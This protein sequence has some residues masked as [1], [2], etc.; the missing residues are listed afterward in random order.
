MCRVLNISEFWIFVNLWNQVTS[1]NITSKTQENEAPQGNIFEFFLLGTL[2][3]TFSMKNLT[4]KFSVSKRAGKATPLPYL[5]AWSVAEYASV[6]LSMPKYPWKCL[7]KLFWLCQGF[8]YAWS[9]YM[10]DRLLK[11]PRVLNKPRFWIWHGCICK[12]YAGFRI[13]SDYGSIRLSNMS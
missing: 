8:D 13:L 6:S 4:Q 1:I 11:M 9:S 7:N 3:T 5:P 2:K 10:F 12:G